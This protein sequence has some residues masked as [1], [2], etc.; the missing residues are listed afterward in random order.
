[1]V[2]GTQCSLHGWCH[3]ACHLCHTTAVGASH[4]N[5]RQT[6]QRNMEGKCFSNAIRARLIQCRWARQQGSCVKYMLCIVHTMPHLRRT[7]NALCPLIK[8]RVPIY[9]LYH[10]KHGHKFEY[11]HN[12]STKSG[13]VALRRGSECVWTGNVVPFEKL[14]QTANPKPSVCMTYFFA[15]QGTSGVLRKMW[16]KKCT[17]NK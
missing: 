6:G 14:S 9:I 11:L 15:C 16:H 10:V 13:P 1:M 17:E 4:I 8:I 12:H 3:I 7:K 5:Q 2:N